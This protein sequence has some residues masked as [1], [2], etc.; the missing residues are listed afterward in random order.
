MSAV[1]PSLE[2][3]KALKWRGAIASFYVVRRTLSRGKARY[4][5][6][7]VNVGADVQDQLKRAFDTRLGEVDEAIPYD[8]HTVDLDDNI[9]HIEL[10]LTDF[11]GIVQTITAATPPPLVD[12]QEELFGAWFYILRLD[13]TGHPP[14]F[15]VRKTPAN[16]ATK[17]H[18][19]ITNLIF[20]SNLELV[21][22]P[23]PIF[24]VDN[25]FDFFSFGESLFIFDKRSFES[26]L[27]FREGMAAMKSELLTDFQQHSIFEDTALI[28]RVVGNNLP[29]LRKVATV[30]RLGYYQDAEFRTKLR[31][32]NTTHGLGLEYDVDGRIVLSEDKVEIVLH[33][34]T[35][36]RVS[37][38][39][40]AEMYD[41][42]A[43]RPVNNS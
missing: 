1:S 35:N 16:W 36:G 28:E 32:A 3:V 18:L 2:E 33:F 24:G 39:I 41:V 31:E 5:P 13:L 7:L 12:N 42:D 4:R 6:L 11:A 21:L 38:I 19:T 9:L 27:N 43:K 40:N 34:F 37:S 22:E 23:R 26:D 8:F 15:A 17:R 30:K 14:L 25:L 10:G 29:L 20:T